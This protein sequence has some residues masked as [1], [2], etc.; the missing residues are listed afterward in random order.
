MKAINTYKNVAITSEIYT[1]DPHR[2][3]QLLMQG[4]MD[5]II[6]AKSAMS[7]NVCSEKSES[8]DRALKII[9]GLLSSIDM[10]KG[11]DLSENLKFLYNYMSKRI[12]DAN[13][14]NDT[15]IL[16]EVYRLMTTV[17]EG[18][19]LI[20]QSVKDDHKVSMQKLRVGAI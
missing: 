19:D 15:E 1:A 17:K 13:V 7:R 6:Q 10:E 3:I 18:W 2:V 9:N 14:K 16:D 4:F 5:K 8:L 20:P 12:F 11:G